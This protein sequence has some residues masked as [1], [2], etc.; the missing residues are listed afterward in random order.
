MFSAIR[1][2]KKVPVFVNPHADKTPRMNP[3]LNPYVTSY[4]NKT[5]PPLGQK[6]VSP[7]EPVIRQPTFL[8]D[9][10]GVV[11]SDLMYIAGHFKV[12]SG[13]TKIERRMTSEDI[14]AACENTKWR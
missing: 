8:H 10:R 12:K 7:V 1:K 6:P 3:H 2:S 4:G 9:M 14:L 5:R 11:I 13:V